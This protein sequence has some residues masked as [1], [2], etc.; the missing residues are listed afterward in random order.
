MGD[1]PV[2]TAQKAV[3]A[4][5]AKVEAVVVKT[6]NSVVAFVKGLWNSIVTLDANLNKWVSTV[7][8]GYTTLA[9]VLVGVAYWLLPIKEILDI[10]VAVPAW[11]TKF[12]LDSLAVLV[13]AIIQAVPF[14]IGVVL[15]LLAIVEIVN[16]LKKLIK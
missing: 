4:D 2:E 10:I 12:L 5:V 9:L 15:V 1:T 13:P 3:S 7:T 11:V 16:A 8:S 14:L 6:E